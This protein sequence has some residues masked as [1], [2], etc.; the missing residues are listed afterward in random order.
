MPRPR[1]RKVH[2]TTFVCAAFLV[3][4]PVAVFWLFE[5]GISEVV[6]KGGLVCELAC[7][8]ACI[9][10]L[11]LF[12]CCCCDDDGHSRGALLTFW[13]DLYNRTDAEF[14][15][16]FRYTWN[17]RILHFFVHMCAGK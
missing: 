8:C 17:K 16:S 15:F 2:S 11:F 13:I 1:Q 6:S 14:Y 7:V 3:H 12:L 5:Q 9:C 4:C 10:I